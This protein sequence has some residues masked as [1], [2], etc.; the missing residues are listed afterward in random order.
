MFAH[1]RGG[2]FLS[3]GSAMEGLVTGA[4]IRAS[5]AAPWWLTQNATAA[6]STQTRPI[7]PLSDG[8]AF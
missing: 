7:A 2:V 5:C 8:R 1:A 3:S 4:H 6:V